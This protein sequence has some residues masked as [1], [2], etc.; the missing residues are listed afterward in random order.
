MSLIDRSLEQAVGLHQ[1]GRL[2]EAAQ[3]YERIIA[4]APGHFD[5]THLLG[6]V[7][8]QQGRLEQAKRLITAALRVN[9]RHAVALNNLGMVHL[10]DGDPE[11]A[12][13]Q[14]ELALKLHPNSVDALANLGTALRLVGRSRE[15]LVPLRHAHAVNTHSAQVSNLIGACLMDIGEQQS[16]VKYFEAATAAEPDQA[17]GWGNLAIA[18]NSVGENARAREC[19]DK[20]V[21]LSPGSS[22]ALAARGAVEFEGGHIE[23]AIE[24]YREAIELP[25]PSTET[26]CAYANALWTSGRCDEA[27]DYLQKSVSLNGNNVIARW[28]LAMSQCRPFYETVGD[29]EASRKAFAESIEEL[30]A[31]FREKHRGEAFAAVGSTQPFFIAYHPFNNRGL[32]SSYGRLCCEWMAS[33]PVDAG[34]VRNEAPPEKMRIGIASAHIR[35][36]SVWNAITK[37][38]VQQ[39]DKTRFEIFIFQLDRAH[40]EETTKAVAQAAHFEKGPKTVQAWART[41]GDARLDA[42]I[43]PEIGMDALT[44]QL[45]SLRLAPVQAATW[46][47]A[48]TTG[49]PTMDLFISAE[50][51]EPADAAGNYSE[52]LVR[53]PNLGV[54]VEP[55]LPPAASPDL[56]SLGLSADE[57][58]LLCP[59][60]PFKYS[61]VHDHVWARIAK[62]LQAAGGRRGW[63]GL[64]NRLRGRGAG[65][66]VFFRSGSATMD[67]LLVHRLRR[68]FD[69]ERADFDASVRFIPHLARPQ[70]FGL[71][72]QSAL[73]LDTIG[74]SGFN[75]ALQAIESGLPV[76]AHEGAFMRGRL[77]SG[78]MRR[79]ELHELVADSDQAFI[80][81]AVELAA[82]EP[83][84]NAL[85]VEIAKRRHILFND[86]EPV[87]ALERCLVDAI[88]VTRAG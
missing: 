9:P 26:Y 5:A 52:R 3:G 85:R 62:G 67:D 55:L 16:A 30:Q 14:F 51:L 87:R 86:L 17:D 81:K 45:A 46:G 68:A 66:M 48:E 82:N 42:L 4:L 1:S 80:E 18:L 32:L 22:A 20:A 84:R 8:L 29:L 54:H 53:L 38:W 10:R 75:N 35:N 47:H 31:W 43:Y 74:F 72:Q 11:L 13:R 24:T 77:A 7:A 79:L 23:D 27:L 61:P 71:M 33:M 65:R 2:A 88:G 50:G 40:D 73:L 58:L 15:A 25:D 39:L 60:T 44:T 69:N 19:V 63:S 37:G 49:L 78:I 41:I 6:V 36:H 28:K 57:P 34:S 64:A 76:L 21:A 83:K 56:R 70:F 59:G 12:C